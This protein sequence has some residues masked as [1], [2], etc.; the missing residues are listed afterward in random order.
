MSVNF[1]RPDDFMHVF[2]IIAARAFNYQIHMTAKAY[3]FS[4]KVPKKQ[5]T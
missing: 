1:P 3:F 2:F 4:D 5:R